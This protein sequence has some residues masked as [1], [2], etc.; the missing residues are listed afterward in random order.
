MLQKYFIAIVP[1]EPLL[2]DIQDLKKSI[3]VNYQTKGALMSPGHITLH[4]PF[5]FDENKEDK[6]IA[7][8]QSFQFPSSLSISLKNFG[9]FEPRVVYINVKE[10]EVLFE[11]QKQLVKHV[12]QQLQIFN[13]AEDMRGFHPHVTIA[14]RDL[15]K[16]TFYRVWEEFENKSFEQDFRCDS[17]CLLKHLNDKWIVH[18]EFRFN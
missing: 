9:R 8:L 16:P 15:K 10:S 13:Q 5:S 3:F 4:M 17:I 2:S 1:P 14:F 11:L 7:C 12:K 6:L 18:K